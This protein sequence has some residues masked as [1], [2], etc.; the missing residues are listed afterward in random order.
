MLSFKQMG[1]DEHNSCASQTEEGKDKEKGLVNE[2]N[3]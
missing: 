2:E 1:K 3:E